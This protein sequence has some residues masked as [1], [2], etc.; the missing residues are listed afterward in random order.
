MDKILEEKIE[1]DHSYVSDQNHGEGNDVGLPQNPNQL[2]RNEEDFYNK[3][4][5][6]TSNWLR[7]LA[8]I[9]E[10][11]PR[12]PE[13]HQRLFGLS[14]SISNTITEK[15]IPSN[16]QQIADQER[17][18]LPNSQRTNLT[19]NTRSESNNR[20][21][22]ETQS[23]QNFEVDFRYVL[24]D[25]EIRSPTEAFQRL[26]LEASGQGYKFFKGST[27]KKTGYSYFY[28]KYRFKNIMKDVEASKKGTLDKKNSSQKSLFCQSYYSIK[29][30]NDGSF[31]L[32]GFGL[33]HTHPGMD[34]D[35]LTDSMKQDLNY[36][37]QWVNIVDV[38]DYLE[39][40]YGVKRLSYQKVYYHFRKIKPLLGPNDCEFFCQ[41]LKE[42][43]F[44][45]KEDIDP[46]DRTLCKLLFISPVMKANYQKFGDIVLMD[47]TY[48]TNIYKAPLVVFSGIAWNGKNILFGLAFINNETHETY[49]WIVRNFIELH[50]GKEPKLMVTDGDLAICKTMNE[51]SPKFPHFLCQWHLERN[52]RR[53]FNYL[54]KKDVSKFDMLVNLAYITEKTKFDDN[55]SILKDFFKTNREYKKSLDYLEDICLYKEKWAECY[56]PILFTAGTNTTSR[57]ESMNRALKSYIDIPRELS[58][59]IGIIKE[60]DNSYAFKDPLQNL[61]KTTQNQYQ[62]DPLMINIKGELGE[63]I[64][65]KH[66][67]EYMQSKYYSITA[68]Q[69]DSKENLMSSKKCY[70]VK[71]DDQESLIYRNP[72]VVSIDSECNCSCNLYK[73]EGIIC[74]HLFCVANILQIKDLTTY[75]H[76]RWKANANLECQRHEFP[77]N[78]VNDVKKIERLKEKNEKDEVEKMI[79]FQKTLAA[80]RKIGDKEKKASQDS[81]EDL[82]YDEDGERVLKEEAMEIEK[83]D[84]AKEKKVPLKNMKKVE[85]TRGRKSNATKRKSK[86]SEEEEE[87]SKL[88]LKK[89]SKK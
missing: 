14:I 82:D 56:K 50:E 12:S 76:P 27:N 53:N 16:N 71:R 80:A 36:I 42:N 68:I 30:L 58:G 89:S 28:C 74:R 18:R 37:P 23:S 72:R 48:Q 7:G 88:H 17:D 46:N 55:V 2:A 8:D 13:I 43:N 15:L 39:A 25:E 66:Y 64:Y 86:P 32:S 33:N 54:K 31:Q 62:S 84:E 75:L 78:Y 70:E 49:K 34:F 22:V 67:F 26:N 60:L 1:D 19:G 52:I 83:G 40:K 24:E 73:I 51:Y 6:H 21:N 87:D 69:D 79:G 38:V 81:D 9:I 35:D 45:V 10:D 61:T 63:L 57:I 3:I 59:M 65:K 11:S 41:H 29:K 44:A 5:K 77:E 20:E 4:A 47:S 85:G